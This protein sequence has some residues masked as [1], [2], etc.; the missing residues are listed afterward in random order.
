MSVTRVDGIW[1]WP[2]QHEEVLS[3][4]TSPG[5]ASKMEKTKTKN[6]MQFKLDSNGV[7]VCIVLTL[8]SP[9]TRK[10]VSKHTMPGNQTQG[11]K[12]APQNMGSL[13][14]FGQVWG[15]RVGHRLG[16]RWNK[17]VK[18]RALPHPPDKLG[19]CQGQAMT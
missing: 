6:Y 8:H 18:P 4:L 3:G 2:Q 10:S 14:R 11:D 19:C 12:R 17:G 5:P 7:F 16:L 13:T 9:D 15:T 1:K